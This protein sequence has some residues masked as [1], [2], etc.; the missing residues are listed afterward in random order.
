M[1]MIIAFLGTFVLTTAQTYSWSIISD[2]KEKI[3]GFSNISKI[4]LFVISVFVVH[5]YSINV[6]KGVLVLLL[7]VIFCRLIIKR[8]ISN[9]IILAF[10][11]ELIS[12]ICESI[13]VIVIALFFS[14]Y[15]KDITQS[16]YIQMIF[17]LVISI[18][19]VL[20][21][22]FKMMKKLYIY[23][24]RI[25]ENIKLYQVFLF[26]MFA[27]FAITSIFVSTYFKEYLQVV[28]ITN[29]CISIAY[30]LIVILIFSLQ[31]RYYKIRTEYNTTLDGLQAKEEIINEY[32]VINHENKNQLMTIKSLTRNK[33]VI[34]Y[35]NSLIK[36]KN[37][38][39]NE[40][41]NLSLK[42]PEGGIRGLL[43]NKLLYMREMGIKCIIN[44]D[45][46][47]NS[48]ILLNINDDDIVD[49]CQVLGVFI[50]NS[51]DEVINHTKEISI[52]IFIVGNF[53][54]ISVSNQY[55]KKDN[56]LLD[57]KTTKGDNHGYGLKLVKKIIDNNK[58]LYNETSIMKNIITQKIFIKF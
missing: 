35:I 55:E 47:V 22:R 50:D 38:F 24:V 15:V 32:R 16:P 23:L 49:I 58:K 36:Q 51:I 31:N 29:I 9:C 19:I 2:S 54:V 5:N 46:K 12:I 7:A 57:F 20:I 4:I 41:L 13:L 10:I 37:K 45:R 43:Y 39:N 33:K 42:V 1:S 14:K 27:I 18:F 52:S 30:S 44:N 40:I 8:K 6:S 56:D 11:S 21:S 28:V 26:I 48:K 53:L 34:S 25:T 3:I 17:D